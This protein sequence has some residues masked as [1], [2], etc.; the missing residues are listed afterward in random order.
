MPPSAGWEKA[1]NCVFCQN[2]L[3]PGTG[4]AQQPTLGQACPVLLFGDEEKLCYGVLNWPF[5]WLDGCD[6]YSSTVP[7][8][9][10]L[11]IM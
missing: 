4:L 9:T 8:T 10:V 6:V 2:F 7:T 5:G 11:I 1:A 3:Y